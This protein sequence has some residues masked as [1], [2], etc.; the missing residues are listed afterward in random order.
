MRSS[1]RLTRRFPVLVAAGCLLALLA[2]CATLSVSHLESKPIAA[3]PPA[4]IVM[5]YWRFEFSGALSGQ[6]FVIRGRAT[7]VT[8]DLP[9]WIDRA[10][11]VNFAAYLRDPAGNV[12]AKAEKTYPG[13]PLAPDAAVSFGYRTLFG[14]A[15]ARSALGA[16]SGPPPAG[17]VVFV[18][19]GAVLKH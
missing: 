8:G 15:K 1:R 17:S 10:E 12:L 6:S 19:E 2:G 7:P 11:E 14:S 9:P 16:K 3:G 5:K 13:M 4:V 18:G